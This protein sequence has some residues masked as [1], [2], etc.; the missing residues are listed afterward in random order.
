VTLAKRYYGSYEVM[1][2]IGK[3]AYRL[4]VP[5]TSKIHPVFHVSILKAFLGNG[6]KVVAGLPQ[7]FHDGQPVKQP[8]A[9]CDVREVLQNGEHVRQI[10][11]Q[12]AGGSPEEA[13]WEWLSEFQNAYPGYNLEYK[14]V[15]EE[16]GNVMPTTHKW[17]RAKRIRKAPGWQKDFKMG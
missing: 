10:L 4:V 8:L 2:R 7:E 16:R 5:A 13:T 12:W 1:E 15:F 11:V 14:V 9:A 17:G 3:V 6:S